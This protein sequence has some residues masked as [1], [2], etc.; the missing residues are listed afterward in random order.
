VEIKHKLFV[1]INFSWAITTKK[2]LITCNIFY[3]NIF[4]RN[5]CIF[6]FDFF[7]LHEFHLIFDTKYSWQEIFRNFVAKY[8]SHETHAEFLILNYLL[9][10]NLKLLANLFMYFSI[11]FFF[12]NKIL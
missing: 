3:K 2:S 4:A 6:F 10:Y 8:F 7:C 12:I 9:E 11:I 5:S 1:S